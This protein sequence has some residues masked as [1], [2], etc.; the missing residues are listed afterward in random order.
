MAV[1]NT[2]PWVAVLFI[3]LCLLIPFGIT[4]YVSTDMYKKRFADWQARNRAAG[5]PSK[6]EVSTEQVVL[7]KDDRVK[8]GKTALVYK[9]IDKGRISLDLYL[10]ELDAGYPY[11]QQFQKGPKEK[12]IRMG[13][14]SY[15][16]VSVNSRV[17]VLNILNMMQTE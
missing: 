2:K 15:S 4:Y 17:L 6:S 1:P 7:I 5:V 12:A 9:G 14:I 8:V 10:L 13:D 16:L 11:P 3:G